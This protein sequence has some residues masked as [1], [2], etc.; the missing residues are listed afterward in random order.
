MY[1]DSVLINSPDDD[2][3]CLQG[4]PDKEI[5]DRFMP[6]SD[7]DENSSVH[8]VETNESLIRECLQQ[9]NLC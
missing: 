5:P 3:Y 9:V 4:V 7:D 6:G 2:E 8:T 1:S